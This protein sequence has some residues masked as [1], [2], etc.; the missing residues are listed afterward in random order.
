MIEVP[1][2]LTKWAVPNGEEEVVFSDSDLA[3]A[4]MI[5][6]RAWVK[7][8]H[9]LFIVA[10][11]VW[12]H[13]NGHVCVH[14]DRIGEVT[15]RSDVP[16]LDALAKSIA[17][18]PKVVRTVNDPKV[19]TAQD[20]AA[21][22]EQ[23]VCVG[24]RV[25][26][27]RQFIDEISVGE[28][29]RTRAAMVSD[30]STPAALKL[31]DSE[32]KPRKLDDG[33]FYTVQGDAARA[34]LT[35]PFTVLTGGPGTGKTHTLT[36]SMFAIIEALH[37]RVG[38]ELTIAVC[39]PTGKAADR[40]TELLNQAIDQAADSLPEHVLRAAR[41]IKP[42][43][44][45]SL[46]GYSRGQRTR[47]KYNSERRLPHD[48]VIVDETSMV[49][50]QMMARLLEALRDDARVLL[51]GDHAQLQSVESGSVLGDMVDAWKGSPSSPVFTLSLDF[52]TQQGGSE[53][54]GIAVVADAIRNGTAETVKQ[55]L[56][57]GPAGV[58]YHDVAA[59]SNTASMR[60]V[61]A[62]VVDALTEARKLA[63]EFDQKSHEAALAAVGSAKLLCGPRHGD[64]GVDTWNT[65]LAEIL[66]APSATA[67]VP[68]TP[69]LITRNTPRVGLVNGD[70]GVVVRI[71]EGN[72]D[73]L[74]VFFSRPT[75]SAFPSYLTTAELPEH[76]IS[77]AMT[78]HKSQGSEY[79]HVVIILPAEGSPLLTR[80]LLYTGFTRAKRTVTIVAS[81][82]SLTTAV[83]CREIRLSGLPDLL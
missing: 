79:D 61:I 35:R 23:L 30:I 15:N 78:I 38:D 43:T 82:E 17:Q 26:T 4:E 39:A 7:D 3:P 57:A 47:F 73:L 44:I 83:N 9:L 20:A 66:G 13:R 75:G 37:A 71:R 32:I 51:V 19:I 8:E 36:R 67:L 1:T 81:E 80:E 48:L 28:Q 6:R 64:L 77:Y 42:G 62:S 55:A 24:R 70:L 2:L 18:Y 5:A 10:M 76:E 54:A 49:S 63:R 74:R 11:A 68:G 41:M 60:G 27:Q 59:L 72:D 46:L 45:H 12:A 34:M 69:V 56:D 14:L 31:I 25:Y 29:L 33:S 53:A 40:V 58:T 22:R 21:V 52:R 50:L 16:S 65:R